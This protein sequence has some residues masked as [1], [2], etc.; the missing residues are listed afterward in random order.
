MPDQYFILL[1]DVYSYLKRDN[2]WGRVGDKV[3]LIKRLGTC[4]LVENQNG[5]SF[6]VSEKKLEPVRTTVQSV[7]KAPVKRIHKHENQKNLF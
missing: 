5:I 2:V 1:T 3:R 4:L 7:T 6:P